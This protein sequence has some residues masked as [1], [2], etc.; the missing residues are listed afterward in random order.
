MPPHKL[1]FSFKRILTALKVTRCHE[2]LGKFVK[3]T[4]FSL[5]QLGNYEKR[6]ILSE[7]LLG[8]SVPWIASDHSGEF[9]I[10][11]QIA[12]TLCC[13]QSRAPKVLVNVH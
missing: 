9:P 10:N 7:N 3:L 13:F 11:L 4:L 12:S 5:S 8:G 6:Q 2:S 1:Q